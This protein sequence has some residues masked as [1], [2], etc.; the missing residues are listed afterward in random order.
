MAAPNDPSA[1]AAASTAN[2]AALLANTAGSMANSIST[3]TNKPTYI[4]INT[5][6]PVTNTT[7]GDLLNNFV[8]T[9]VTPTPS[10]RR[11][12]G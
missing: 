5:D 10:V 2:S 4:I 7:A 9:G 8:K 11:A 1:N 3:W 6:K 12:G